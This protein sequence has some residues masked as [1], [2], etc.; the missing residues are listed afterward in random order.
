MST[1]KILVGNTDGKKPFVVVGVSGTITLWKN[2]W[3]I[4]CVYWIHLA[5]DRRTGERIQ[6]YTCGHNIKT[7]IFS[8]KKCGFYEILKFV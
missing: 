2:F 1:N 8:L 5:Q 7:N 6:T 4:M 3:E